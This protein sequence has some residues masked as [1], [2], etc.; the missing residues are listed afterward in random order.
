[1]INQL[2]KLKGTY[3]NQ[4]PKYDKLGSNVTEALEILLDEHSIQYLKV[5]YRIKET[6]SFIGKIDRKGY[7]S[8]FEEIEDICGVRIICYYGSEVE[9]ICKIINEQ[10]QVVTSQDKEELLKPDQFGYRS[11]HFI[12]KIKED[13]LS[14][15]NYKGLENLKAEIQI[16][17]NLMHTW[18]EIEHELG[19][20]K[21]ED[22][23][24]EFRRRFSRLSA[25]LEEADEQFEELKQH[26]NSY[27]NRKVEETEKEGWLSSDTEMNI[28]TLKIFLD[29][30]LPERKRNNEEISRETLSTVLSELKEHDISFNNLIEWHEEWKGKFPEIEK[31]QEEK[32]NSKPSWNQIGVVRMLLMLNVP[33]YLENLKY[34]SIFKGILSSFLKTKS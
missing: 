27:R 23:P 34:A 25:K 26:I 16:R 21:E 6:D 20:K 33:D 1:M 3:E 7:Q 30:Y 17:T 32:F 2:E 12:I 13:W 31:A 19:Y 15:P 10:F 9:K 11:H 4:L 14:T 8:P 24:A 22:I 28:D 18:A 5:Y 29:T